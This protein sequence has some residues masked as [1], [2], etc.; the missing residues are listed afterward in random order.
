VTD[1]GPGLSSRAPT[2][3]GEGVGLSNVQRRLHQLY[4]DRQTLT[5]EHPPTGGLRV[6]MEIPYTLTEEAEAKRR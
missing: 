4:G 1:D 6:L 5:L 3:V 2:P